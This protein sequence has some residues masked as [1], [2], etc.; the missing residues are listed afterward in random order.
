MGATW[1]RVAQ[2]CAGR[3]QT[4]IEIWRGTGASGSGQV[5]ATFAAAVENAVISVCRYTGVSSDP[6]PVLVRGNTRG[7]SG[8][9]TGGTDRATY[10]F[11]VTSTAPGSVIFSAVAI[12]NRDHTPGADF[13]ELL[14][15]HQGTGGGTAGLAIQTRTLVTA[16][17]ISVAGTLSSN[18]DWAVVALELKRQGFSAI[19]GLVSEDSPDELSRTLPT[20]NVPLRLEL[21]SGYPNPFRTATTLEYGLPRE[22]RV[23]VAIYDTRG[24]LVRTLL[25]DVQ[26]AGFHKAAWDGQNDLGRS[27]ATGIYFVDW[28]TVRRVSHARSSS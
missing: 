4:G 7:V 21:A 15:L 26:P 2:Q 18:T 19:A 9:C 6:T 28:S 5:E 13:V 25:D 14:E 10:T 16:G 27:V 8:T 11:G 20:T 17:P 23:R 24:R 1:T 3:N 12:R 22:D